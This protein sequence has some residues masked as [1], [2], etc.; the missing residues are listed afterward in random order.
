MRRLLATLCAA[1]A[2]AATCLVLIPGPA[3]AGAAN[4]PCTT[5]QLTSTGNLTSA[6][7]ARISGDGS[8]V[9]FA[10]NAS[11]R[12]L[13]QDNSTELWTWSRAE[14]IQAVTASADGT[15]FVFPGGLSEGGRWAVFTSDADLDPTPGNVDGNYELFLADRDAGTISQVTNSTGSGLFANRTPVIGGSDDVPVVAFIS[16]KNYTG[17]ND[18]GNNEVFR[19]TL[20]SFQQL[21]T[22]TGNTAVNLSEMSADGSTIAIS[23]ERNLNT[24]SNGDLNTEVFTWHGSGWTQ[25]STSQAPVANTDPSLSRDGQLVAFRSNGNLN[26]Q[27]PQG[28]IELWLDDL[29]TLAPLTAT[30]T[31][32]NGRGDLSDAGGRFAWP[33]NASLGPAN[34]DG[35]FEVY[36]QRHGAAD[37]T[38]VTETADGED[39]P[40]VDA[41]GSAA[42]IVFASPRNLT[43]SNADGSSEVF[44]STCPT[45]NDVAGSSPF[46]GDVEWMAET[47]V[48]TGF[49]GGLY[50]PTASVSRAAMAAFMHRLAGSPAY[51]PE[52]PSFPDVPLSHPFYEEIEWLA[53]VQI[54]TG[55]GDGTFRPAHA[56]TRQSMAA[57][58]YRLAGS[59]PGPFMQPIFSDVPAGSQFSLPIGWMAEQQI[60]VG[61]PDGTFRPGQNVSRQAMSAFMHRF[62]DNVG[63]NL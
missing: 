24:F 29:G 41:D 30:T 10:S 34:T 51:E 60:T 19:W 58:M 3:P 9:L 57:F 39:S 43:G 20:G 12:R 62:S 2:L 13:N 55:F 38:K 36:L 47:G 42:R 56:V 63:V 5:Q 4:P 11:F 21:T 27:N 61:F 17:G 59:P 23:S 26:G 33:S 8:V 49:G 40:D 45:F 46:F 44:L 16:P 35:D 50:K 22:T 6:T 25:V 15:T 1:C 31:G 14:G 54:T 48:S 28:N 32:T 53:H 37:R 7:G 52:S 18:D